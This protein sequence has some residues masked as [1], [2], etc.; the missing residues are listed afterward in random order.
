MIVDNGSAYRAHTLQGVCARLGIHLIYCRPYAPEGKSLPRTPIRGPAPYPHP[1][2]A[3]RAPRCDLLSPSPPFRAKGWDRVLPGQP[4]EVP[5]ELSGKT[6]PL[7]VDPH[8]GTVVG[9]EDDE[10]KALRAA[11]PLDAE[12]NL[13]RRRRKLAPEAPSGHTP[14]G[15]NLVELAYRQYHGQT[16]E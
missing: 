1:W 3:C 6:V 4:F 15:P 11:T 12:A 9:V 5:Y 13:N 10:G 7:V 8:A 14:V 2:P 16:E